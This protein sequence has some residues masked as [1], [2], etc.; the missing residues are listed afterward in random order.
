MARIKY[1]ST[2]SIQAEMSSISATDFPAEVVHPDYKEQINPRALRRMSTPIRMAAWCA[3]KCQADSEA[4]VVV[5]TGLG[6]LK[7]S[8]K[9]LDMMRPTPEGDVLDVISPTPFIQ[10]THNA[11]AG[12]IAL[13]MGNHSY[14]VTHVQDG[15]SF[16]AAFT[17]ACLLIAEGKSKV[18]VGAVDEHI[19]LLSE[20]ASGLGYQNDQVGMISSG[21]S[22]FQLT[23]NEGPCEIA[24]CDMVFN[25]DDAMERINSFNPEFVLI[26][27]SG[28]Y[29][30]PIALD[31]NSI[32]YTEFCGVYMTNAAFGLD[33]GYHI[34]TSGVTLNGNLS[35]AS[36]ISILNC[37][38]EDRFGIINIR[39]V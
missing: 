3:G 17:D 32:D 14:N 2:I 26:G 38:K 1:T 37:W 34:L 5:G 31:Q 24:S 12:Q 16:E 6:C 7:D 25:L 15:L 10:S 4:P 27:R 21:C 36:S 19:P 9:F 23:E 29:R 8:E 20:I 13:A 39:R 18:I 30:P 22:F 28:F 33:L 35:R 11:M